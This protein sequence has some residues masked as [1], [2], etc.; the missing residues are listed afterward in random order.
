MDTGSA[1]NTGP[2]R[3]RAMK[4]P[5][6]TLGITHPKKTIEETYD[7][8]KKRL[9]PKGLGQGRGAKWGK[10]KKDRSRRYNRPFRTREKSCGWNKGIRWDEE[11][12][13]RLH[14]AEGRH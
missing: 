4:I 11:K 14:R 3:T 10:E 9:K 8:W 13:G 7:S 12:P 5:D 2:D 6:N 1:Q